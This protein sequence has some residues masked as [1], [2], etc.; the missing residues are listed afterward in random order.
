MTKPILFGGAGVHGL[1]A[2]FIIARLKNTLFS[3]SLEGGEE[4][5]Y[6]IIRTTTTR[7]KMQESFNSFSEAQLCYIIE[8][9]M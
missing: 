8:V 7:K 6:D 5:R 4:G 3:P 1:T 9:P 2:V